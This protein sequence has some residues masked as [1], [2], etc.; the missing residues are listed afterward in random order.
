MCSTHVPRLCARRETSL[1]LSV[2]VHRD[3]HLTT[4]I[5]SLSC[6]WSV[7]NTCTRVL[8]DSIRKFRRSLPVS[9]LHLSAT[10][11]PQTLRHK[12]RQSRMCLTHSTLK[13]NSEPYQRCRRFQLSTLAARPLL[14]KT[15]PMRLAFTVLEGLPPEHINRCPAIILSGVLVP[16]LWRHH[17]PP[18]P[19]RRN[20]RH[21]PIRLVQY[22]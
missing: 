11:T 14:S 20:T 19:T 1:I 18:P 12:H 22:S 5:W 21:L 13:R 9:H 6:L 8:L 16:L 15:R 3:D 7:E 17:L 4:S 2:S 10:S